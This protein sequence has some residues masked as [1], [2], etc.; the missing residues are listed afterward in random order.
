YGWIMSIGNKT[1]CLECIGFESVKIP[2][3]GPIIGV[4]AG[5]IGCLQANE[6]IKIILGMEGTLF[7]T[8]LQYDGINGSIDSIE[9]HKD[10]SCSA[11]RG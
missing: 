7:G 11:H 10:N 4:T 6:C 3:P 8:M 2:K 1:A 9:L 5:V